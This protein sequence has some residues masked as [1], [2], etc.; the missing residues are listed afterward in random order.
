MKNLDLQVMD[1]LEVMSVDASVIDD[2]MLRLLVE[3][4]FDFKAYLDLEERLDE[5]RS[6]DEVY[7]DMFSYAMGL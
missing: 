7:G 2:G 3:S 6:H 4:G 1:D 5:Y